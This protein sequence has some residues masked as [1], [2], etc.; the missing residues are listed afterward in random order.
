[1]S[2]GKA[3]YK[4]V[5]SQRKSILAEGPFGSRVTILPNGLV[6]GILP[7]VGGEVFGIHLL[8]A[9]RSLREPDDLRGVAD[10][11]HRLLP[12]GTVVSSSGE[13]SRRLERAGIELKPAGDDRPGIRARLVGKDVE[14]DLTDEAIS[15]AMM[16][17]L[18]P[19]FRYIVQ[20]IQESA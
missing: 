10:Y 17:F 2:F 12:A 13:I 6:L 9:D 1:M 19:R 16:R 4:I 14:I 18:L 11:M 3:V 7:E 8:V 5:T 20:G 15:E